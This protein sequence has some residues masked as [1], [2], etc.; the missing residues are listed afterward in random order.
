MKKI[1]AALLAVA[2]TVAAVCLGACGGTDTVK[3][4]LSMQ[5]NRDEV[6]LYED[7]QIKLEAIISPVT[8][9][10]AQLTWES[11]NTAV[12]TVNEGVVTA[13]GVGTANITVTA[14][15]RTDTCVVHVDE[16]TVGVSQIA[17]NYVTLQ[18][19]KGDTAALV[20]EILPEDAAAA[21]IVWSSANRN[22]VTVENGKVTAVGGGLTYILAMCD[23]K[24]AYCVVTVS[25]RSQEVGG[26]DLSA[27]SLEMQVGAV[28]TLT[29]TVKPEGAVAY[30]AV[31]S[32]DNP[33]VAVVNGGMVTAVGAGK[34]T[35]TLSLA[36]FTASCDIT[37]TQREVEVKSVR[38]DAARAEIYTGESLTVNA[39][40]YP[41]NAA[42]KT[43]KWSSSDE[44]VAVVENGVVTALR[45][46]YAVITA[47]AGGENAAVE[48]T[49]A[50][51]NIPVYH[52]ETDISVA[53]LTEGESVTVN[54]SVYPENATDKTVKWSSSDESVA[55]VENGVVTALKPG[56]ATIKAVAGEKYA[57]VT[58]A[59]KAKYVPAESVTLN[60]TELI[61]GEGASE[62]LIASVYPEN[63]TD[64]KVS[65]SSANPL[66]AT[67]EDG[68]VRAR[69][70]GET[71]I[72][73]S[74]GGKT[75]TV[76]V[77]V[78]EIFVEV[79]S[80]SLNKTVLELTEGDSETLIATVL[81]QNATDKTISWITSDSSVAA[82]ENGVVTALKGGSAVIT[83]TAG[84]K[85]A[86]VT[87][88]VETRYVPV[89]DIV[90]D[91]QLIEMVEDESVTVN[92]S[93]YPE[94]AT[95]KTVKWESSDESVV[96]VENGVVTAL[97]PGSAVIT[98]TAGAVSA[99]CRVEIS[100]RYYPVSAVVLSESAITV[101]CEQS[102]TLIA[103][104][105]PENASDKT[106]R[107]ESSDESVVSVE[108]GVVTGISTG[109]AV[110]TVYAADGKSAECAVTVLEK[111]VPV[112]KI[113]LSRSTLSIKGGAVRM[114]TASIS[115][116]NATDKTV[117][118]ES[119]DEGVVSVENGVVTALKPGSATVTAYAADGKSA[120]CRI[121]VLSD[122]VE[123]E[124]YTWYEDFDGTD[125]PNYLRTTLEGGGS[126]AM[127]EGGIAMKLDG[128]GKAF[129]YYDFKTAPAGTVAL[130]IRM[131][132]KNEVFSGIFLYSADD[133]AVISIAFDS[134]SIRNNSGS[135]WTSS[136][137]AVLQTYE[138]D[139][140][141][142]LRIVFNT[143]GKTFDL[144]I[145][146][147][148]YGGLAMRT[149]S[150]AGAVS[151]IRLGS[152]NAGAYSITDYA[153]IRENL[154]A[155]EISVSES[156]AQ[157]D[158]TAES[159][160][161]FKYTVKSNVDDEANLTVTCDKPSGYVI[162]GDTVTFTSAGEYVFT[163]T[164][165]DYAGEAS[166]TVKI[167]VTG[168]LEAPS[169]TLESD[170]EAELVLQDGAV[171]TLKFAVS[172]SPAPA[173]YYDWNK[174]ATG[175]N[176]TFDAQC[177]TAEFFTAGEYSVTVRA[178]NAA[179][180][181][182]VTV[183]IT[184]TDRYSADGE[185]QVLFAPDFSA[186]MPGDL[187]VTTDG[188]GKAAV[189]EGVLKIST[190]DSGSQKVF[191]DKQF[192]AP[193]SG[194]IVTEQ[195]FVHHHAYDADHFTNMMFLQPEGGNGTA[196][197]CF[198]IVKGE[199]NYHQ[200]GWKVFRHL[201]Q[202]I[203][204]IAG[205]KYTL[206][207]VNDMENKIS[208]VYISGDKIEL[209]DYDSSTGTGVATEMALDGEMYVG[210]MPFRTPGSDAYVVRT[211]GD[212]TGLNYEIY[213][214]KVYS[215][216]EITLFGTD[217]AI[218]PDSLPGVETVSSG[219]GKYTWTPGQIDINVGES[220]GKAF[221]YKDFEQPLT[222]T[223]T[224][225]MEIA[226]LNGSTD[227]NV[228]FANIMF[229]TGDGASAN[230]GK[231]SVQ[232]FAIEKG[233][234][235]YHQGGWKDITIDGKAVYLELGEKYTMRFVN[236][237]DNKKSKFYISGGNVRLGSL[238]GETFALEGEYLLGEYGFRTPNDAAYGLRIG[239]DKSNTQFRVYSVSV[240]A[241]M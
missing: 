137:G 117:R 36:G 105:Y 136:V 151:Y 11:D 132:V 15:Q 43:V 185:K 205:E 22:V 76:T 191:V 100:E 58:V 120:T 224:V 157:L 16:K 168:R 134:G 28:E 138:V 68:V 75:A 238:D 139:R 62:R 98:A 20:A 57:S 210:E 181:A 26:V 198:A 84:N 88:N 53:V 173:V 125:V 99:V 66:I 115:P 222:G 72:T 101:R 87:V 103:V 97:R 163:L 60:K 146:G 124:G 186:G 106:L 13:V 145:D 175:G 135:G 215:L 65:W 193:L 187:N 203:R 113:T 225:T 70:V 176:Y 234:L 196:V 109:S 48:I 172:G 95:D 55:C 144:Y 73:A 90:L 233:K 32:S 148:K 223:V 40:V 219:S 49:V 142:D 213:D 188:D 79:A 92:A 67:V 81:P 231:T 202:S 204:F 47:S 221:F 165:T 121:T 122:E 164:A 82:I 108:N 236:D 38:L 237:M 9:G 118:W 27:D 200:G 2:F 52:I 5:L 7:G 130:D 190:G 227:G 12:A 232:C 111:Y 216:T 133:Q 141:Y 3:T 217:F 116:A 94:N 160:Y 18:L 17:L 166:A 41:E 167:T 240:Q 54:A 131:K 112:E 147:V 184:V 153:Y 140:Y 6:R 96:S 8:A 4:P 33:A 171:Y 194:I 83:A 42:D 51:K 182:E 14:G 39:S 162:D 61:L 152:E 114:L 183:K 45:P 212:K 174:V 77:K 56:Y 161:T 158:I 229:L 85:S 235:R 63:A 195:T 119:S 180:E 34:A 150:K 143:A 207:I 228:N 50:E 21:D 218:D 177:G 37:V 208:Y 24:T 107:W 110:I 197:A 10:S 206:R 93:V 19:E 23:G 241:E 159:E 74:V 220:G 44:E 25:D 129:V 30:G 104:I 178:E 230:D 80:V 128:S 31:W 123:E 59:V 199:L 126:L 102:E 1:F 189:E 214:Y 127:E 155:P 170:K 192:D 86:S 29:Y 179:G 71:Q 78:T 89:E 169:V 226:N 46:G 156:E 154:P 64:K 201:G 35:I 239:S 69:A 91:R 211:G 209:W 149:P